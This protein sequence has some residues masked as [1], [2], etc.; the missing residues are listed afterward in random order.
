[1]LKILKLSMYR[2]VLYTYLIIALYM[3]DV[4]VCL[5]YLWVGL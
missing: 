1:M 5:C 2:Y 4:Y 3:N